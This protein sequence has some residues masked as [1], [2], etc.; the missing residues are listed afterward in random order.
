MNEITVFNNEEFGEVREITI[1][2]EP[3]FI[4][5]DVAKALGYS[6]TKDAILTHVDEDDKRVIQRSEITT[7]DVP[8]RGLTIIN[9][10][11]MYALIFGSKLDLAKKFKRWVTHDVLPSIRK[12]GIY[13]V[14]TVNATMMMEKI[15]NLEKIIN[16]LTKSLTAPRENVQVSQIAYMLQNKGVDVGRNRL[17]KTLRDKGYLTKNK[18]RINVASKRSLDEGLME[19]KEKDVWVRGNNFTNIQTFV[20]PK[21]QDFFLQ[22]FSSDLRKD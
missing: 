2:N 9:E 10:S 8:N 11:G 6:N 22:M 15:E 7:L 20:T 18:N 4:G 5:K 19:L 13:S 1:N 17:I 14:P 3:W 21:G 12:T 16:D